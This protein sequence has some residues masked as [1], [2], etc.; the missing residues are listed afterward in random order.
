MDTISVIIPT[1]N[2]Y[3]SLH[4]AVRSVIAQSWPS[5]EIIVI[6]DGSSDPRT[7]QLSASLQT[8]TEG[9]TRTLRVIML[10][11]NLRKKYNTR[12][13]DPPCQ[14]LVRNE[15]LYV[16]SGR[17]I[18]FLDDDDEWSDPRK[19][20]KQMVAM[21][22]H[23]IP[24]SIT[25]MTYEGGILHHTKP[26]LP[27]LKQQDIEHGNPIPLSTVVIRKDLIVNAGLFRHVH[28]EDWDCWKRVM[29]LTD[30]VY[31]DS[32]MVHYSTQSVKYY[33]LHRF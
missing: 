16:A 8:L 31:L 3:D 18:A 19:L 25:N 20:E 2:R 24:F 13:G 6:D 7:P 28:A 9:T 4:N 5:I 29:K 17:W 11:E 23:G 12:S 14:G 26:L 1:Y 10:P 22:E 33:N 27:I 21:H 30:C 32:P 15:G